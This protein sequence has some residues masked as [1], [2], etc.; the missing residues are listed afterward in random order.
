VPVTINVNDLSL[1][2]KGSDGIT[3]ATAPDVCLTPPAMLPLPYPNIAYSIDLANGTSTVFA[4]GGNSIAIKPSIFSRSTGDEP[5]TG[6]GVISGTF[7]KEASWITWSPDVRIEGQNACRLTDKMWHNHKNTINCAGE[8]QPPVNG[9]PDC[10]AMWKAV[11]KEV[12]DILAQG[13]DANPIA[14][15][16]AITS[17]YARMYEKNP[18]LKWAGMGAIVSKEAGCGM[19]EAKGI[20]DGLGGYDPRGGT[21]ND[22]Y[23][24]LAAGNKAIFKDIY[25]KFLFYSKYG[26]EAFQKCADAGGVSEDMKE[27]FN[28]FA[29]GGKDNIE[30]A[31]MLVAKEEQTVTLEKVMQENP[32]FKSALGWNKFGNDW[33]VGRPFGAKSPDVYM[34][35]ACGAGP[36]VPF[37]GD[38]TNM[39]DRLNMA[40]RVSQAFDQLQT[41][42]PGY[43]G[44]QM[45]ILGHGPIWTVPRTAPAN[46]SIWPR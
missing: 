29:K 23:K 43:F 27:A 35:S 34:S 30:K 28:L 16:K 37:K 26:N 24:G 40:E 31:T 10:E 13:G 12:D 20:R 14:R 46:G 17:A 33:W 3:V 36:K 18:E 22:V 39:N 44:D 41:Q 5:G 25:P 1:C 7:T 19:R 11:Q 32:A 4:D 8:M 15:N 42:Y 38:I 9:A 6:G 45:A 2:H 21:A